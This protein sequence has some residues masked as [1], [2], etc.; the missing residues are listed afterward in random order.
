MSRSCPLRLLDHSRIQVWRI[1]VGGQRPL[2]VTFGPKEDGVAGFVAVGLAVV[3][4]GEKN[5]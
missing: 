1:L 2:A 3:L 5:R 4:E